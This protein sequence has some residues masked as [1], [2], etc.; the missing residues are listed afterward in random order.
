VYSVVLSLL[1]SKHESLVQEE[2][3]R[4]ATVTRMPMT[5]NMRLVSNTYISDY[6]YDTNRFVTT[7]V[8]SKSIVG[9]FNKTFDSEEKLLRKQQP[10]GDSMN[11]VRRGSY[12]NNDFDCYGDMVRV[13][14]K[15]N[16]LLVETSGE[17]LRKPSSMV[18]VAI[19]RDVSEI[20]TEDR[21]QLD[22]MMTRYRG[23]EGMWFASRVHHYVYPAQG[24]YRQ[25]LAL[26]RNFT[27]DLENRKS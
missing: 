10:V 9:Y 15:N 18:D 13:L 20:P 5:S 19:D 22:D 11:Y 25:W 14:T 23:L 17:I 21:K 3:N 1:K 8:T 16:A 27:V 7:G 26:V 6:D 12:W 24:R 4:I 2:Q